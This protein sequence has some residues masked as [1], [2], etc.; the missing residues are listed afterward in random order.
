M[1]F[2]FLILFCFITQNLFAQSLIKTSDRVSRESREEFNL[3]NS[4]ELKF[5]GFRP[6][7]FEEPAFDFSEKKVGANVSLN[8]ASFREPKVR[9]YPVGNSTWPV[10]Y[11]SQI[12]GT[13]GFDPPEKENTW[14]SV[15]LG[16]MPTNWFFAT[17]EAQAGA[18]FNSSNTWYSLRQL[19]SEFK[20]RK[21]V[22]SVGRKP[23][24]WGQSFVAPLLLS[25][26]AAS[27]DSIQLST[28][29]QRWPWIFKYL[30][31]LKTELFLTRMNLDR[32]NPHDFFVGW[33]LGMMPVDFF[34]LNI[35]LIY[36]FSGDGIPKDNSVKDITLEILG[37][38]T[39]YSDAGDDSSNVT[40]RAVQMD[41]RFWFRDL[42]WPL[43][44]YS[45][46]HLEDC[47]GSF[48]PMLKHSY[49]FMHGLMMTTGQDSKSSRWRA[50]YTRTGSKL[51]F[52]LTWPSGFSNEG[53]V[54]GQPLGPDSEGAYLRWNRKFFKASD[55]EGLFFWERRNRSSDID[56]HDIHSF[57]TSFEKCEKR[58]GLV[59]R[60]TQKFENGFIFESAISEMRIFNLDSRRDRDVW[61]WGALAK[62][63]KSF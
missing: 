3:Q 28:L 9:N 56:R 26:H 51:Y 27:F 29:P 18:Q 8:I 11:Q 32:A 7:S 47:C 31:Q 1:K 45:E 57:Y 23:L 36:Q 4:T 42:T 5:M 19:Y 50:E 40:N 6:S 53:R 25:D 39:S 20:I 54:L 34:E 22:L 61:A 10:F 35:G 16:V 15:S 44:Y 17:A 21:L 48:Q 52:H 41:Y 55:L 2:F 12:Q 30:G 62:I 49:S 58:A 63:G 46:Q 13:Q 38:R 24:Y 60:W 43:S 33:R 59:A 14:S 37:A